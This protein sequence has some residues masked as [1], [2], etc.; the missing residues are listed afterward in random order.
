MNSFDMP[1]QPMN[2]HDIDAMR[3]QRFSAVITQSSQ[4]ANTPGIYHIQF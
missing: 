4:P 2:D 3:K 1:T